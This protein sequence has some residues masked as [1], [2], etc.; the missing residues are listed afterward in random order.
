MAM[1]PNAMA[2]SIVSK[3]KDIDKASDAN[4]AFYKALCDYVEQNAMA[5]Y[6]WVGVG[7]MGVPD[8]QVV[9]NCKI[10]TSG[11]LSPSGAS[12]CNAALST[13]SSNLNANAA[14]W[15]VQWPAG[16]SL[17]PA[18]VIPTIVITPS[19][20]TEMNAAWNAVCSQIIAGLKLAT[21]AAAG[22]HAAFTGTATF[23]SLV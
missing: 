7:P 11:S 17:S 23:T 8:P 6:A 10:K 15:Q 18:F 4:D 16:F 1:V 12:D 5:I 20:A 21:P 9:L 19:M 22:S 13:L 14:L 3:V 2:S